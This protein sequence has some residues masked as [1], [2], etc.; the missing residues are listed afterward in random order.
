[1][2]GI[3]YFFLG[4]KLLKEPGI[5][6]FVI[7][8][9]LVNLLLFAGLTWFLAAQLSAIANWLNAY[10]PAWLEWLLWLFW[11]AAA[12]LWLIVYGFSFA[13]I[14]NT[15]AAPFYGLLAEKVQARL[16][17]DAPQTPMTA[18][19]LMALTARTLAREAHKL[20]YLLPRFLL[21]ALI[22]LPLYF[23]PV[24][25]LVV[26]LLWFAWGAWSLALQNIDYAADNNAMSFPAMRKS[27]GENR[28]LSL[29]FGAAAV[30]S[31]SI[32]LFNLI[33]VPAAVAGG[34][35]M[36]SDHLRQGAQ[37]RH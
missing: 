7:L 26:P 13:M 29:S 34:T 27:M 16:S 6:P 1:M 37:P 21:L 9:L 33:A 28:F 3:G 18:T 14:S 20:L 36:W 30:A 8:P 12:L 23:I 4:L 31:A 24:A 35:A 22:S 2:S 11:L 19:A 32:P 25:G 10:L 15:I 5:R 17:L